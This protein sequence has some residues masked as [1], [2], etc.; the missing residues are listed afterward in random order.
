MYILAIQMNT[1]VFMLLLQPGQ[2]LHG[3][4]DNIATY[5]VFVSLGTDS[6]GK[7]VRGR[8]TVDLRQEISIVFLASI[9]PR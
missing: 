4:I 7:P 8:L 9:V 5:G 3:I 1:H 2:R 6:H